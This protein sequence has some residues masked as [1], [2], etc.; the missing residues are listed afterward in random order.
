MTD[1]FLVRDTRYLLGLLMFLYI[2][3]D[4]QIL[5]DFLAQWYVGL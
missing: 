2:F 3:Q 4:L 1:A 5:A